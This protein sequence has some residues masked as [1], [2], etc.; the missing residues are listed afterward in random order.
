MKAA[1]GWTALAA[2]AVL[3]GCGGGSDDGGTGACTPGQTASLTVAS[4]GFSPRAVCVLPGGSV[5]LQNT[6]SVP[7][8]VES[9]PTC[10]QLNLG[11]VGAGQSVT[12]ATFPTAQ[13]CT[14]FD[15]A[16]SNDPAFQGT[17]AVTAGTVT[18]PGY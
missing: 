11:A 17:V 10:T 14:F 16:H 2:A 12:T 18:G 13:T 9:G 5:T 8:D 6:D 4:S 15:A 3:G 1:L 7:H